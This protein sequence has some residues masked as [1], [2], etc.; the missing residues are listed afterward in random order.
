VRLVFEGQFDFGAIGVDLAVADDQVLFHNFRDAQ[1]AQMFCGLLD[2]VP[3]GVLL[4]F[5][6]GADKFDNVVRAFEMD[7]FLGH[8]SLLLNT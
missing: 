4:T 7:N 2:D 5:G 8:T 6:A 1:L 3:C